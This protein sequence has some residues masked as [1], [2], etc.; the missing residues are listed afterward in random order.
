METKKPGKQATKGAKQIVEENKATLQFYLRM[1]VGGAVVYLSLQ[2]LLTL[3]F[4][5]SAGWGTITLALLSFLA[6]IGSFK[7]MQMMS[8]PNIANNQIID[9][10][11]DLCMEG[12]IA[13]HV[14]DIIILCVATQVLSIFWSWFWLALLFAPARALHL[15]WGAV[16]KPWME[17][18]NEKEPEM[19]EKKKKKLERKMKRQRQ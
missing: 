14:K 13:E 19:D 17:A 18:K 10:G 16:I 8:R 11:T 15:A 1:I 12:G 2:L 5:S 7:F 3:A 9:S 6:Q 4:S